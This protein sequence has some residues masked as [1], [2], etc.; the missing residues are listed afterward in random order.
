MR[1]AVVPFYEP[2]DRIAGLVG[3]ERAA[4]VY[5]RAAA[6][7]DGLA[8]RG[9]YEPGQLALQVAVEPSQLAAGLGAVGARAYVADAERDQLLFEPRRAPAAFSL[10][11]A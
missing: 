4:H 8:C 3:A 6:L 7:P 10:S 1:L 11:S 5:G 9:A 2:F